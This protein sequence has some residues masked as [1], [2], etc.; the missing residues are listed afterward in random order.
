MRLS[1]SL[2]TLSVVLAGS[3]PAPANDS[4]ASFAAGGLVLT[5][6]NDIAMRSED[7]SVS[8]KEIRV[9]YVFRNTSDA[10]VTT[11]VAF[12]VPEIP[13]SPYSDI[14]IPFDDP[15][16]PLGF[17]TR[18]DGRPVA[19]AL[20]QK[21]MLDGRDVTATLTALGIPLAPQDAKAGEALDAL[22]EQKQDELIAAR[23]AEPEEF[24]AGKGWERHLRPLWSWSGTYHWEQRFEPGRDLKVEH[25]YQPSVGG[26]VATLL[27]MKDSYPDEVK[28]MREKYCIDDAFM[29]ALEKRSAE[30][31][32]R[33]SDYGYAF[34]QASFDYVL[35][36]G[37]NWSE[38]IGAFRL[39]VDKGAS[40][41]LVSFCADGV[42]KISPTTFEVRHENFIPKHDLAVL[43]LRPVDAP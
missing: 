36:T 38:P 19:M 29:R 2:V 21:A 6:T 33:N 28:A 39:T 17:T 1:P 4:T 24:D 22:P 25:R 15:A 11:T 14:A 31:K 34:S 26:S 37:A 42:A 3:V 43:I 18:V 7:L 20:D 8:T 41:N 5:M 32:R 35:T 10:A 40:E 13:A 27:E 12:P 9:A 30:A 16:N 23:I